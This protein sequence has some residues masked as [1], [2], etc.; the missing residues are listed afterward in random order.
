MTS[1]VG[2]HRAHPAHSG[3]P[4]A[5]PTHAGPRGAH[6]GQSEPR[7]PSG[8]LGATPS[9]MRY[10]IL[11]V[12]IERDSPNPPAQCGEVMLSGIR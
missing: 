11:L 2:A 10:R 1:A 5:H 3:A 4:R 6:P 7:C 8:A 9:C 12:L